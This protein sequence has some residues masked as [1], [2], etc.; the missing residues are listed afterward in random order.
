MYTGTGYSKSS[1]LNGVDTMHIIVYVY[2]SPARDRFLKYETI[3]L[4]TKKK[5]LKVS[6]F[7]NVSYMSKHYSLC[8][9]RKIYF[10]SNMLSG[11]LV[12]HSNI[13]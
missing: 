2:L 12:S 8:I 1:T 9:K 4:F 5:K 6:F 3:E 10:E 13:F 7:I 11:M